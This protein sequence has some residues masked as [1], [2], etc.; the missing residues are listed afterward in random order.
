[1]EEEAKEFNFKHFENSLGIIYCSIRYHAH[2][3]MTTVTWKGTAPEDSE[4]RRPGVYK[5][6]RMFIPTK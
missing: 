5:K 2:L 3:K 4:K 6:A 1:M